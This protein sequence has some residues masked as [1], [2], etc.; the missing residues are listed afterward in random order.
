[1]KVDAR[2][3]VAF[4]AL[5]A[6]ASACSAGPFKNGFDLSDATVSSAEIV[7]GGPPRDGIPALDAPRFVS[8]R[9]A[10]VPQDQDRVLGLSHKGVA[11]AYPIAILNW[12]EIVNDQFAGEPVAVTYCPLALSGVAYHARIDGRP[13]GFGTSG[14]LYNSNLVMYDRETLSL[15]PQL[16]NQ[17]VS[18]RF[19]GKSLKPLPLLHTTWA[20][21]RQRHPN[22]LV[23]SAD[24]GYHRDYGR[25]PYADY[26]QS[27]DPYFPVKAQSGRYPPKEWVLGVEVN[28]VAKAYPFTELAKA[29]GEIEDHVGGK[30][31]WVRFDRGHRTAAVY[32][33]DGTELPGVVAYWFAWYAFHP[34]TAVFQAGREV[35]P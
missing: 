32:D 14:L 29:E 10:G 18:G 9:S 27:R 24:T 17:A 30:T 21:W 33:P 15:W 20:D 1:M 35:R 23:L 25:D 7:S 11:K 26:A 16:M 28:G 12:H 5:A 4:L 6:L 3:E 2:R 13:V 22:T 8:A 34:D 31:A 19:K